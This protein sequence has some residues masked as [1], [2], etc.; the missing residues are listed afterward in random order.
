MTAPLAAPKVKQK[1]PRRRV[2][3]ATIRKKLWPAFA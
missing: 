3:S 1:R 2:K